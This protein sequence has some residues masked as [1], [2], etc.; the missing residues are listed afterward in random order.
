V[1]LEDDLMALSALR[2]R[3]PQ[4]VDQDALPP[5]RTRAGA[6]LPEAARRGLIADLKAEG[7][8]GTAR[9]ARAIRAA[10][11]EEDCAELMTA[12]LRDWADAGQP[13][14]DRRWL[15]FAIGILGDAD[16]IDHLGDRVATESRAGQHRMA[17]Y[18]VASLARS[19]HPA[20]A[21]WLARLARS[22][23]T[24]RL[25][26]EAWSARLARPGGD[27]VMVRAR[28]FDRHGQRPFRLGGRELTLR[29]E[30]DG[31]LSIFEGRRRLRSLPRAR[32]DDDPDA[33]A[34]ARARFSA[35]KTA[36]A[37]DLSD[38]I[39]ALTEAMITGAGITGWRALLESPVPH[40]VVR[41]VIWEALSE[42]REPIRF[43]LTD[44]G[45]PVDAAGAD[46]DLDG[47]SAIRPVHPLSLSPEEADAWR[48][49]LLE[50]SASPA[51]Q[52]LDRPVFR[53]IDPEHPFG[54][55]LTGRP[56]I[57]PWQLSRGLSARG[58]LAERSYRID[59][60]I[61]IIGPY[62]VLIRHDPY[63]PMERSSTPVRI[64]Q[65]TLSHGETL[66]PRPPAVLYS[67][68]AADL[69]ALLR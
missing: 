28:G 61:R 29:L 40:F 58:Y 46:L 6:V 31:S 42:G 19:P 45:D 48:N 23:P 21:A 55:L 27:P 5:L 39:A 12:L 49:L 36:L 54:S 16:Y 41:G 64:Q 4:W 7:T 11:R 65:L 20:A 52:Q 51:F 25:R 60:A 17:D 15:L 44:E 32:R 1:S 3:P 18:C 34:A 47:V 2:T 50:A 24:P 37:A 63:A 66:L 56:A 59:H 22:G 9:L 10:L 57:S 30:P 38:T 67:E 13:Q 14:H 68:I 62:R 33:V 26:Q 35:L 53:P 69:T 8:A 43:L